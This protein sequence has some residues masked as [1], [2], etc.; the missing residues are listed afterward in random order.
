MGVQFRRGPRL[1]GIVDLATRNLQRSTLAYPRV[2]KR[3]ERES[4]CVVRPA[5]E[6]GEAPEAFRYTIASL[7]DQPVLICDPIRAAAK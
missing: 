5:G 1:V 3:G 2:V 7:P 6:V 4:I